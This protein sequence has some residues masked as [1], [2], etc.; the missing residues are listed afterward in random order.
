MAIR[1]DRRNTIISANIHDGL[2][3]CECLNEDH[4]EVDAIE[5]IT[6]TLFQKL[7]SIRSNRILC[8]EYRI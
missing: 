1:M 2:T 7:K 5:P 6:I 8:T 4:Q 3:I